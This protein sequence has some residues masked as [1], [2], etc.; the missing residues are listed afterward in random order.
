MAM[1]DILQLSDDKTTVL[2]VKDKNVK[3]VIIPDSVT[4][5][6]KEAFEDCRSL[7]NIDIPDSVTEIGE[8]AFIRCSSL[9]SINISNSVTEI[10]EQ[11]F[12]GCCSLESIDI[13]DSVTKIGKRAF[14]NC[15]SLESVNVAKNNSVYKSVDGILYNN[16][17]TSII[18]F[19][20]KHSNT[21]FV[22]PDS[23]TEIGDDAFYGCSSLKS[24]DIPD[25]VTKIGKS[26]F[27]WCSSLKSID[28]PNSVTEIGESAFDGCEY[29]KSIIIRCKD[30]DN[31]K[32]GDNP[33]NDNIYNKSVLH[34]PSE[35]RLAYRHHPIFG[36]F[37]NIVTERF[38]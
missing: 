29:I 16:K 35:T 22:I 4:K 20:L 15:S 18:H 28:I 10:R 7:K 25:S 27:C 37:K 8:W 5:I 21:S 11:A 13:P 36:K 30:I 6:G 34:I 19:P 14:A 12:L 3:S 26:A 24:V 32:I 9:K 23:V 33:F 2:S 31:I 17:L 38:D 1:N